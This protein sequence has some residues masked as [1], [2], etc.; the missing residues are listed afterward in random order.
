[1]QTVLDPTSGRTDDLVQSAMR[2]EGRSLNLSSSQTSDSSRLS[3]EI[4]LQMTQD[5]P[6]EDRG[7]TSRSTFLLGAY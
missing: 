7:A 1:M 6:V 3:E 5:S 2:P 4:V